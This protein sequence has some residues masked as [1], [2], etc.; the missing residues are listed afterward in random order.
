MKKLGL[1]GSIKKYGLWN[2]VSYRLRQQKRK[3]ETYYCRRCGSKTEKQYTNRGLCQDCDGL[4]STK[5]PQ[6]NTRNVLY[7]KYKHP[8]DHTGDLIKCKKCRNEV[9][10]YVLDE[11]REKNRKGN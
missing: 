1:Y 6:C 3:I 4:S 5:C 9:R 11:M 2:A 10:G 7:I 8:D